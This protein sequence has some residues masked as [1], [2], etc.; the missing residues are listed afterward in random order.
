MFPFC[1][2]CCSS[3]RLSG[4]WM[5]IIQVQEAACP[6]GCRRGCPTVLTNSP[7]GQI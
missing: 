1:F 3:L 5:T 7:F 6:D 4:A 2:H